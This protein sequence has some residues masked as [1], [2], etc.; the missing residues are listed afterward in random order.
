MVPVQGWRF[1]AVTPNLRP[2]AFYGLR[3]PAVTEVQ[4]QPHPLAGHL[5]TIAVPGLP[6]RMVGARILPAG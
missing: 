2:H 1:S 4:Q 3:R 5:R 6:Q